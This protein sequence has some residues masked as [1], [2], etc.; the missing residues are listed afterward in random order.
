V[1]QIRKAVAEGRMGPEQGAKLLARPCY[2][3]VFNISRA[4]ELLE[5]EKEPEAAKK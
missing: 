3:G 5:A 4:E 1:K 2:C